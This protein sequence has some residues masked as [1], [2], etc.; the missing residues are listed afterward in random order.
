MKFSRLA[1][2]FEE[3]EKTSSGNRMREILARFFKKCPKD[4]IGEISY[5]LLGTIASKFEDIDMG[6]A[7]KMVLKSI[8]L[9]SGKEDTDVKKVFKKKGD[10][11]LTAE[12]LTTR[13]RG[14]L[15]VDDVFK[16]LWRI[17]KASG[18]GSQDVKIKTLAG[19]LKKAS[20][21][22]ARY[23]SRLVLGTLRLGASDMTILDALAIAFTGTK[24][25]KERLEDAYN[26]NPDIGVIAKTV[27]K[28]GLKG[29]S[30]AGVKF[31]PIQSMLCQRIPIISDVEKKM[32]WPVAV[33]EKYDGLRIQAHASKGRIVLYSRRL[34][35]ITEQYPDVVEAVKRQVK[36][37]EF[38]TD[39]EVVAVDKKGNSLSF[40]F[41]MQRKR[42]YRVE[43]YVKKIPVCYFVFDLIYL[44]GKSFLK[45][46]YTE[47]HKALKKIVR[48]TGRLQMVG[49]DVCKDIACVE[50]F[51]NKSLSHGNEG[52]L[53]KSMSKNSVYQP[54]T[55]GWLWIKWKPEYTKKLADTFD[56]VV[57][58]AF[59]GRGK[60]AGTYGALLCAAYN[61]KK[62]EF[63]TFCKLGS[64]FTDKML[65]ELPRKFSRYRKPAK[66]A[67]VRVNK[68]MKPDIW[69]NPEIVVEVLGAEITRSPLH[70]AAVEKGKGL[71]LRFPRFKR[72][73]DDKK[74]EQATNVKEILGMFGKKRKK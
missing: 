70:T 45:K 29:I 15:S 54:G 7:E 3:L 38:I 47:R 30:A 14:K 11:G 48:Q 64:G 25:N 2:V 13:A 37:K 50:K 57:V 27:A 18:A 16:G 51:F 8:A 21:K 9:D 68:N 12:E 46:P 71:A 35:N 43:E 72:F 5:L 55:R 58:G 63:E 65:A 74:P 36:A 26:T 28:K 73:R 40:Q 67:R 69:F 4:E 62:D 53:I 31:R 32:D 33:E 59:A 24:A 39:G 22:E 44:N 49:R 61:K 10:V 34:E 41:L 20:P 17:A 42:K 19:L 52:V 60:R 1:D 23:I 6:M 66:P 56:L